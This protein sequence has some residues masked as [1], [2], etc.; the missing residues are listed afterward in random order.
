MRDKLV[1]KLS[2]YK[3]ILRLWFF[4]VLSLVIISIMFPVRIPFCGSDGDAEGSKL[5]G[6]QFALLLGANGLLTPLLVK[7]R[8]FLVFLVLSVAAMTAINFAVSQLFSIELRS[9]A[10]PKASTSHSD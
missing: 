1:A 2:I 5:T 10:V 3:I 6:G 7:L 4:I 8:Y 9:T